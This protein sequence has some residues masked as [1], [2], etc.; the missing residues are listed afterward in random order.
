MNDKYARNHR[1]QYAEKNSNS[2][3]WE[4]HFDLHFA[5]DFIWNKSH[6]SKV[7][8]VFDILNVA[9]MLNHNWGTFYGSSYTEEIISC[10][11]VT[12]AADGTNKVGS[13]TYSGQTPKVSDYSSRWHMQVGLRVTF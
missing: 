8:L 13:F 9:N 2:A 11:G 4:N 6:K 12:T 1:G 7:S 10:S 3:P 5:Q